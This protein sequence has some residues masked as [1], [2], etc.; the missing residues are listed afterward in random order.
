VIPNSQVSP[1][2]G[3][4]N[5]TPLETNFLNSHCLPAHENVEFLGFRKIRL[6]VITDKIPLGDAGRIGIFGTNQSQ[7]EKGRGED[8]QPIASN[9]RHRERIGIIQTQ[10]RRVE[11]CETI[12]AENKRRKK[13]ERSR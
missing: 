12:Q 1:P 9:S 8:P 5:N 7:F 6:K 10:V 3:R 13:A 11:F 2:H 4:I